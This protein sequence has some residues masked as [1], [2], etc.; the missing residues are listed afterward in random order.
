M[1]DFVLVDNDE[2]AERLFNRD[3]VTEVT[4]KKKENKTIVS[5]V[6]EIGYRKFEGN[7]VSKVLHDALANN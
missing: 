6:G 5:I 1:A 2:E 3:F 4:Y 7:I